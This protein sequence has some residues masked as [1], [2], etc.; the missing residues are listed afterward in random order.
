MDSPF[1]N[2]GILY[3]NT[4]PSD[5]RDP[6][7]WRS[8]SERAMPSSCGS[9][10]SLSHTPVLSDIMDS[11]FKAILHT[12]TN[13]NTIPPDSEC[14]AIH[15]LLAGPRKEAASLMDEINRTLALLDELTL[16]HHQLHEFIDAHL[17][18]VS[19]VHRLPD[20]VVREIFAV[21]LPSDRNTTMNG[22]ES[23]LPYLQGM[24][25]YSTFDTPS[26][27]IVVPSTSRLPQFTD[28]VTEWLSRSESLPLAFSLVISHSAI[29]DDLSILLNALA[30]FSRRWK[31]IRFRLPSYETLLPL[32]TFPKAMF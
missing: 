31:R 11:P 28:A 4:V 17:A 29:V 24:A 12:N 7:R 6:S 14:D 8:G 16:K 5:A 23:P 18:L 20:D 10:R 13:T 21:T 32:A 3:T 2:T 25:K 1:E 22:A 26:L 27:H 15:A 30:H 9:G 19:P